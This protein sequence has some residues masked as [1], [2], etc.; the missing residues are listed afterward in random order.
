MAKPEPVHTP[1][2]FQ[3]YKQN[4]IRLLRTV[5]L[6]KTTDIRLEKI[7]NIK[8]EKQELRNHMR[9]LLND[10]I[11]QTDKFNKRLPEPTKKALHTEFEST[12]ELQKHESKI[13][14]EL[15][16]IQQKLAKLAA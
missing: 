10:I 2:D 9:K 12:I 1:I 8:K 3:T 14:D 15:E 13:D 16:L 11:K 6:I 5:L 7:E 4:K